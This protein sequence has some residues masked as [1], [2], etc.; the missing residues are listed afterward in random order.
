MSSGPSFTSFNF[1]DLV[2]DSELL[3]YDVSIKAV[4]KDSPKESAKRL[5]RCGKCNNCKA[6][7]RLGMLFSGPIAF[8]VVA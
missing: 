8:V 5:A 3:A 2:L 7:V 4:C 6:Q 1:K